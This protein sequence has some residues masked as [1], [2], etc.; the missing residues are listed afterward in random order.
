MSRRRMLLALGV[1]LAVLAFE[2]LL[3]VAL[4]GLQ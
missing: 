2:L 3:T 4:G 1:F